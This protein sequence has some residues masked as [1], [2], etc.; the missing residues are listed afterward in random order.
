MSATKQHY[1]GLMALQTLVMK[2]RVPSMHYFNV[3]RA[4]HFHQDLMSFS[5]ILKEE[6]PVKST[7][8]PTPIEHIKLM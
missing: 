1:P 3:E 5:N 8:Q 2:G 6:M 7:E 4:R